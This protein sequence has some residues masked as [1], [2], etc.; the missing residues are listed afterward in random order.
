VTVRR[1]AVALLLTLGA[2]GCGG[3]R[4]PS[5]A[6]RSTRSSA[7]AQ[8]Q[9]TH[10]YPSPP[11]PPQTA[12]DTALTAAQ[13]IRAF[14]TAYINWNAQTVSADM[15]SLATHSVGQAR[16]AM[17]LAAAGT[18]GDYELQQ[19]GIANSGTVEAVAPLAGHAGEYV[20]VTQESTTA[21]NTTAYQGLKPAWHVAL[22]T[23]QRVPGGGWALSDW[24]PEN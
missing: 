18:A 5:P 11:P 3:T 7:I 16:A 22:A 9:A 10:E 4:A 23:V 24:Q 15:R 19:G 21:S 20:V 8:A 2:S 14:V 6:P 13:A 12:T 1:S 17:T